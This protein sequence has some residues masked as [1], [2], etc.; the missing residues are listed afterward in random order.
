MREWCIARVRDPA[1]QM[2][3]RIRLWSTALIAG[4]AIALAA[5]SNGQHPSPARTPTTHAQH[6]C[7]ALPAYPGLTAVVYFVPDATP[8]EIAAVQGA[9]RLLKVTTAVVL[10]S[11]A[12]MT[13]RA[14]VIAC[15]HPGEYAHSQLAPNQEPQQS[16]WIS[17]KGS[18]YNA[19]NAALGS[20][21]GIDVIV[22]TRLSDIQP[23]IPAP[24]STPIT[25]VP[26]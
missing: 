10:E 8:T 2:S 9:A 4:T 5:C 21:P 11:K 22:N 19:V 15:R 6:A 24:C 12:Q 25:T 17:T 1:P 23:N 14:Q 20:M 18:D 7:G 16:L 3:G 26:C 13:A